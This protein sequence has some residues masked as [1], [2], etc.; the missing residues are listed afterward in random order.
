MQNDVQDL[1]D[2][3]VAKAGDTMTG[4]LTNS[5][6]GDA[7]IVS[8]SNGKV[9]IRK[10]SATAALDVNGA[11]KISSALTVGGTAKNLFVP[12]TDKYVQMKKYGLGQV[13]DISAQTTQTSRYPIYTL[14]VGNTGVLL[15]DWQYQTWRIE[16]NFF[17]TNV[18]GTGYKTIDILTVTSTGTNLDY[19][20]LDSVELMILHL[21]S[22]DKGGFGGQDDEPLFFLR[23]GQANE[24]RLWTFTLGDY[25]DNEGTYVTRPPIN[26]DFRSTSQGTTFREGKNIV[27]GARRLNKPNPG[28]GATFPSQAFYLTIKYKRKRRGQLINGP[29]ISLS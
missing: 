21:Q 14:A 22:G 28:T 25:R 27:F 16:P 15:E 29:Y 11:T 4:A 12:A 20:I 5:T 26:Y 3:K 6:A 18:G 9:A 23:T 1:Q 24:Q 19:L 8:A 17:E 7:I 2:D 10:S 13:P